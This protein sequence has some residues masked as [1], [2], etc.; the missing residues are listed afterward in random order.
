MLP[1]TV[2]VSGATVIPL[3]HTEQVS[4]DG[5]TVVEAALAGQQTLSYTLIRP[6]IASSEPC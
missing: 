1:P 3:E 4:D 2:G 5:A 6:H